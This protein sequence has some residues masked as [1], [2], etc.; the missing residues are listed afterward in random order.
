V[1]GKYVNGR[2][3]N[4]LGVSVVLFTSALGLR[5]ILKALG[6]L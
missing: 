3:S 2:L 1:L 5:L 4:I 6:M